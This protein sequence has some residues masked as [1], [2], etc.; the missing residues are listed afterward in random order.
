MSLRSTVSTAA[1]RNEQL[2]RGGRTLG[3]GPM[4]GPGPLSSRRC[5][6]VKRSARDCVGGT[7]EDGSDEGVGGAEPGWS[8]AHGRQ[9]IG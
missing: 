6:H 4:T 3:G 2:Q 8:G 9:L 7:G 5:S 1:G